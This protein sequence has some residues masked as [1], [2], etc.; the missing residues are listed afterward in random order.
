MMY[1]IVIIG[2]GVTGSAIAR[3]L[4]RYQANICVLEK[5]DDVCSGTS[6]ANSGVVHSGFDAK[7]GTLMAKMN[8]EGNRLIWEWAKLLDFPVK[9]N[10]SLIVCTDPAERG[11]LDRLLE[12]AKE[13]GVEGVRILERDEVMKMEPNLTEKT[14][15]ALYAPTGGIICPFNFTIAM[16]ENA[17]NG[18]AGDQKRGGRLS[19]GYQ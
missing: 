13:N 3:E 17:G 8:V 16:A 4:S 12:Q 6:K 9:K 15:A 5:G 7:P 2:A 10:G 1:D 18:S 11:G 19:P 14:V